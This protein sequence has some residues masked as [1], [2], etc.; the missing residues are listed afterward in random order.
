METQN[1]SVSAQPTPAPA[2]HPNP[3]SGPGQ[4]TETQVPSGT[5]VPANPNSEP[6][7]AERQTRELV[8]G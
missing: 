7:N 2:T 1:A 4:A 8:G 5:N 6:T 3:P